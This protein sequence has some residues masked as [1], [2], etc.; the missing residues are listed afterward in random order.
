M[1][2]KFK[3]LLVLLSIAN[4]ICAADGFSVSGTITNEVTGAP[5][6]RV[7]V[8]L[9]EVQESVRVEPGSKPVELISKQTF[10]DAA[11]LFRFTELPKPG[12]TFRGFTLTARKPQFEPTGDFSR[13]IDGEIVVQNLVITLRPLSVI[14]GR[15]MD[16]VGRP[17]QGIQVRATTGEIVEGRRRSGQLHWVV[18]TDDQGHFRM[19]NLKAG[20]VYLQARGYS[21]GTSY[22]TGDRAPILVASESFVPVYYGGTNQLESA[23]SINLGAGQEFQAEFRL[24][25]QPAYKIR[26]TVRNLQPNQPTK[27]EL[28]RGGVELCATRTAL[29]VTTGAFELSDVV[30]GAY[31]LRM[32]QGEGKELLFAEATMEVSSQDI[33]AVE[34]NCLSGV[35]LR[36]IVEITGEPDTS[37]QYRPGLGRRP[38]LNVPNCSVVLESDFE[39]YKYSTKQQGEMRFTGLPPGEYFPHPECGDAYVT[40]MMFGET[41]VIVAQKLIIAAGTT[42]PPLSIK[43][44]RNSGKIAIQR[45]GPAANETYQALV[46]PNFPTAAGVKLVYNGTQSFVF[47]LAPG[48]YTVFAIDPRKVPYRDP[49][50]IR[51]L[52]NGTE[53]IVRAGEMARV[54]LTEVAQ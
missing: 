51:E 46:V 24:K 23:T 42:P 54:T 50:A 10:T 18:T 17:L 52:R 48:S 26:G 41:D 29:N 20:R 22:F 28:F 34:L 7:L 25:M 9:Q 16:T 40:S 15:V 43:A 39:S 1:P 38:Q 11:G 53:T 5:I 35:D 14:E 4:R 6:S 49:T 31:R 27:F 19:W 37:V 12:Y 45:E 44:I 47:G 13:Y 8:S 30:P 33:N 3:Y 36:L 2:A 21:G 32:T